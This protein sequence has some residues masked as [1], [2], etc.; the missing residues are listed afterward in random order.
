MKYYLDMYGLHEACF[1]ETLPDALVLCTLYPHD[2]RIREGGRAAC[3]VR[4]NKNGVLY[5]LV[6]DRVVSRSV[7]PVAKSRCTTSTLARLFTPS[8]RWGAICAVGV[9]P[10]MTC[11]PT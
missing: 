3:G 2:C 5:T 8:A 4:Y 9:S 10:I 1:Y 6:Y 11:L 7:E